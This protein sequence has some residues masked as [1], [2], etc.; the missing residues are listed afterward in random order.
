MDVQ[1]FV[2]DVQKG[3]SVASDAL[4]E[5]SAGLAPLKHAVADLTAGMRPFGKIYERCSVL[6]SLLVLQSLSSI[7]LARYE[8]VVQEHVEITLFLTLL[9]GAGGNAGNQSAVRFITELATKKTRRSYW[10]MIVAEVK[11]AIVVAS[12]VATAGAFRIALS[13]GV[14]VAV[15]LGLALFCIVSVA[16]VLGA[17]LPVVLFQYGFDPEHAGPSV[18]VAMDVLGVIITTSLCAQLL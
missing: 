7:V 3:A 17:L 11:E 14:R 18:Q 12:V 13:S 4:Q 9:I 5:V 1:R 8:N 2:R 15:V 10:P 16:C 6:C